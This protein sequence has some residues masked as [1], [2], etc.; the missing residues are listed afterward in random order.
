MLQPGSLDSFIKY[1]HE[2]SWV[3]FMVKFFNILIDAFGLP[4]SCWLYFS[5]K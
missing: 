5:V 3:I 4:E 2:F 1:I